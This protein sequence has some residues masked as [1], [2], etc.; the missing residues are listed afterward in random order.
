MCM[1]YFVWAVVALVMG[2]ACRESSPSSKSSHRQVPADFWAFYRRFHTDSLFQ[3]KHISWPL[4]GQ[5][6]E[7]SPEGG[8]R[9]KPVYWEKEHWRLQ[10][11][12]DF[13]SGEFKQE[14]QAMEGRYVVEIISYA[15]APQYGLERR[16]M[17]RGDGR[18]ELVYYADMHER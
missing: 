6:T 15:K 10:R 16:F 12:V 17:R 8:L 3:M 7:A 5:S 9:A 14:L 2:P 1:R 18:W 13:N 4:P 11:P